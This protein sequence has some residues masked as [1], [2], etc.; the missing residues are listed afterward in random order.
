MKQEKQSFCVTISR[1]EKDGIFD[2]VGYEFQL[3]WVSAFVLV[4]AKL[5][6]FQ[7]ISDVTKIGTWPLKVKGSLIQLYISFFIMKIKE[8]F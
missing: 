3:K 5:I 7:G 1:R 6:L 4:S 8:V 2:Q